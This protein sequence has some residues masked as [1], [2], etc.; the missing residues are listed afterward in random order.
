MIEKMNEQH[1]DRR[2][3][4][5]KFVVIGGGLLTAALGGL[6]GIFAAPARLTNARSWRRAA[7]SIDL[8]KDAPMTIVLTARDAD[9]W[10]ETKKQTV[11]FLDRE[12]SG[13]RALSATCAHLGCRVKWDGAD[14]KFKCPCHGGVYDRE[15]NVLAG[16]PPR[17]LERLNVR[18]N[19]QTSDLEVEL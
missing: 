3:V 5:A 16:P 6:V 12:G 1:E 15:G 14:A 4:L 17:G 9:G 7:A 19:P 10:Y 2:S 11:I 13:Y 18:V 8:P